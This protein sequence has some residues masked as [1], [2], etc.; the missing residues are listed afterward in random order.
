MLKKNLSIVT[1]LLV[2][3]I[4][5]RVG[6]ADARL[7]RTTYALDDARGYCIDIAGF[8]ENIRLEDRLQVHTCK[9]GTP[10]GDQ[11]FE[12]VVGKSQLRVPE[13]DVCLAAG[14]LEPGAE[15]FVRPCTDSPRQDWSFAW[16]RLTPESRPDLC[17]SL[18][19]ETGEIAGTPALIT[20]VYRHQELS[21]Q[22]C[23]ADLEPIQLLRW[24]APDERGVSVADVVRRGMPADIA[25]VLAALG[26]T[27]NGDIVRQT[28]AMYAPLAKSYE[29]AEIEIE[30]NVA[31]G[32][33]ERQQFD[34]HTATVRRAPEPVP[35][36]VVF[37]GGGL[38]GGSR[39]ATVGVANFFASLGFV[40]VNATYRLA[41]DHPW[42]A[43]ARDVGAAV[44]WLREN[45]GQYGGDPEQIFV[46][47]LSSGAFHSATYVFRPE[48]MPP[49]TARPAGA[50]LMSGPYTFDFEHPTP[51]EV[52]YF[53]EDPLRYA[54]RV[55]VGNVTRSDVPVL[56]TTAEWDIERYT[57]AFAALLEELVVGHG[58]M[59]RYK[60]SLG[61]NHTSQLLA[62][63]TADTG[64][65]AEL[66]DFI[67]RTVG[68]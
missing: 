68:R 51:G 2:I 23:E 15:L 60:Q 30:T 48:L 54:D 6:L 55:V 65:S 21:L 18:A 62:I 10:L 58:V 66:V 22:R 49:G 8:G 20:P 44:T 50:I 11:L 29:S 36:V 41:P 40:G 9:Y 39:A 57:L 24:S 63:G 19:A 1:L 31:Y 7:L 45:V 61:H 17:V 56:F 47:G 33:D 28:A 5:P 37:H 32:P 12:R 64:V 4:S 34:I 52:A 3:G 27:F 46:M 38:T 67:E 35:S 14:S 53:G 25:G 43:G 59:P 16:G 42:P 26:R 13:Y